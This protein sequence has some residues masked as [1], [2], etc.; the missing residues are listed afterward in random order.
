[1]IEW[2]STRLW[3]WATLCCKASNMGY[4]FSVNATVVMEVKQYFSDQLGHICVERPDLFDRVV[5]SIIK[6]YDPAKSPSE[7]SDAFDTLVDELWYE[8]AQHERGW[9]MDLSV[10]HKFGLMAYGGWLPVLY[11][12]L[13]QQ[14]H[15]EI[16]RY[17]SAQ[18]VQ[19]RWSYGP[20]WSDRLYLLIQE[21][22]SDVRKNNID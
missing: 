8:A 11:D 13:A 6:H 14:L 19:V 2:Q 4:I 12:R 1:M 7:Y 15:E 10:D 22:S 18:P 20:V 5:D 16:K 9:D 17:T 3:R 21:P